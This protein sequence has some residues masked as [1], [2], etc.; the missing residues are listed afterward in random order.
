M[1]AVET[2]KA[3]GAVFSREAG[4]CLSRGQWNGRGKT[5]ERARKCAVFSRVGSGSTHGKG[6]AFATKAVEAQ[7]KG[8]AFAMEAVVTHKAIAVPQPRMQWEH[9]GKGSAAPNFRS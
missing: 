9:C 5:V 6:G 4:R 2:H 1:T 3:K 7:S 8:G